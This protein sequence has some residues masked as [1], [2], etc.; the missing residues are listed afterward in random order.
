MRG[1]NYVFVEYKQKEILTAHMERKNVNAC[2]AK[3]KMTG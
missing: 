3:L 2:C 1:K